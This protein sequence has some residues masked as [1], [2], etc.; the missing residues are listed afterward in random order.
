MADPRPCLTLPHLFCEGQVPASSSYC[1]ALYRSLC[2]TEYLEHNFSQ[3]HS[4]GNREGGQA[5]SS[6]QRSV[7][8][9]QIEQTNFPVSALSGAVIGGGLGV[10]LSLG[11]FL[12][13][14]PFAIMKACVPARE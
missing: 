9:V 7:L 8:S 5:I 6:H 2:H 1:R 10:L 13:V 3:L 4:L 14:T 12:V 11:A